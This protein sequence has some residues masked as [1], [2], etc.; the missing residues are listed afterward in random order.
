MP[1]D[2]QWWRH[3]LLQWNGVSIFPDSKWTHHSTMELYTDASTAIGD[4]AVF[5]Q[6]WFYGVW[7]KEL[8]GDLV[9]IQWKELFPIYAAFF[10]WG[11]GWH[12]E[13]ILFHTD[14]KTDVTIWTTQTT[15][16]S[17]IM[18]IVHKLFLVTAKKSLTLRLSWYILKAV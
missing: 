14:N 4:G 9:S 10:T 16:S 13:Q 17:D 5:G 1:K 12:G 2:I 15:K 18:N 11:S 7:P 8:S 3:F 6:K